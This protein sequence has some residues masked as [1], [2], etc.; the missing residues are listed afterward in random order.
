MTHTS[1]CSPHRNRRVSRRVFL[2]STGVI[3]VAFAS[4]EL[5]RPAALTAMPRADFDGEAV[6]ACESPLALVTGVPLQPLI[7]Q[8]T[9]LLAA[10]EYLGEPLLR[11]TSASSRRRSKRPTRQRR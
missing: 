10:A 11:T 9:R 8:V 3:P 7:A 6:E 2:H 1:A 5:L 4:S